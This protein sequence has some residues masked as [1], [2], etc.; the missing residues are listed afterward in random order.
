MNRAADILIDFW[1][2]LSPVTRSILIY[3]IEDLALYMGLLL[4]FED[5]CKL[6]LRSLLVLWVGR[7]V[8]LFSLVKLKGF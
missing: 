8:G 2:A 3:Q 5:G 6:W 1:T 7:L 4:A